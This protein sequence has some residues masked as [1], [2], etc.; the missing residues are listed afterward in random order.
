MT[1]QE[2]IDTLKRVANTPYEH[3]T[4]QAQ[5][6]IYILKS[7]TYFSV[8][9]L[10]SFYL[11]GFMSFVD[12]KSEERMVN[13]L[14][15]GSQVTYNYY[16]DY[17][18]SPPLSTDIEDLDAIVGIGEELQSLKVINDTEGSSNDNIETVEQQGVVNE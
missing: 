4:P 7:V 3:K 6:N 17:A 11:T 8:G 14:E 1:L 9:F 5:R 15:S 2:I 10:F 18:N 16:G 13:F 12:N